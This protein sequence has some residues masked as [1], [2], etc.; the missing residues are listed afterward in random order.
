[1]NLGEGDYRVALGRCFEADRTVGAG[2]IHTVVGRNL[3]VSRTTMP[4]QLRL[5]SHNRKC[6]AICDC[7]AIA[8]AVR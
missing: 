5:D 6:S 7:N 2:S 4:S 1:M 3:V 8:S